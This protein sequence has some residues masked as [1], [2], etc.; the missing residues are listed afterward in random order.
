MII[1][2]DAVW[3]QTKRILQGRK[4]CVYKVVSGYVIRKAFQ[5]CARRYDPSHY[6]SS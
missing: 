5:C 6:N 1:A 4:K 2:A 3:L